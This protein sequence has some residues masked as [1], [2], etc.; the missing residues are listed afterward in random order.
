[1]S[2]DV[3]KQIAEVFGEISAQIKTGSFGKRPAIGLTVSGSEHGLG[4]MFEAAT[5]AISEGGLDLVLIG[6]VDCPEFK[7]FAEKNAIKIFEAEGQEEEHA[8]MDKLL[9]SGEID[10]CVTNHYN[11][12]IGVS[13]VGRVTTPA[14]GKDLIIATTTGT[15][16]T[17]R[18]EAMLRNAIAGVICAKSI[19]IA[20]P[21]LGILNVEGARGTEKAISS[22]IENGY[23]VEFASSQRADGGA[24]M[25]G[26]DLLTASSDVMVCDSLTGNILMKMFSSFNTGGSYEASGYGY[27]PG[28]GMNYKRNILIISRASGARVI[29]NA[30]S[31]AASLTNGKMFD[32]ARAEYAAAEKAGLKAIIDGLNKE[33]QSDESVKAPDKEVVTAEI[34]GID[35]MDLDDAV[36]TIW[37]SGIYAE[38]GMGCTGPIVLVPPAKLKEAAAALQAGG[39]APVFKVDC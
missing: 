31:Y 30:L 29:A 3:K 13:T 33:K 7:A 36:A 24:V 12:P 20:K 16:A 19:G 11:F 23:N 4:V 22:L 5:L 18:V 34:S 27:G 14:K 10:A 39:F 21:K 38:S 1:M 37:K 25:R 32:I 15:S 6:K 35:I 17:N 2:K 28:I 9:D 8:V 26:N